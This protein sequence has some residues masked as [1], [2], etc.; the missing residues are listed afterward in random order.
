MRRLRN[1][2]G[3]AAIVSLV[4]CICLLCA[5]GLAEADQPEKPGEPVD[6][7]VLPN[8]LIVVQYDTTGD[9]LPDLVALH[10]ITWSGWTAQPIEEIEAQARQDDQWMFIVEYDADR[11]IYLAQPAA[12]LVEDTS[13]F[14]PWETI[15]H[16]G[17]HSDQVPSRLTIDG[18]FHAGKGGDQ[19]EW[20]I[21]DGSSRNRLIERAS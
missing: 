18:H 10:Q 2:V 12:L 4:C 13:R 17:G 21:H 3:L 14:P 15:A 1:Y 20:I 6:W 9:G 19:Y 5:V 8:R 11:Y 16:A 7:D